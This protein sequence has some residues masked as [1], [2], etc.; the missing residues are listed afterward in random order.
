MAGD[1]VDTPVSKSSAAAIIE[2]AAPS[3]KRK[4]RLQNLLN[5]PILLVVLLLATVASCGKWYALEALSQA[6][7]LHNWNWLSHP[8]ALLIY[9]PDTD[10]GCGPGLGNVLNQGR[11]AHLDTVIVTDIQGK[12]LTQLNEMG[13]TLKIKVVNDSSKTVLTNWIG[14]NWSYKGNITVLRIQDGHVL[15]RTSGTNISDD[16]FK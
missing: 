12:R 8:N 4:R 9:Y 15:R 1:S 2:H 14:R 5:S 3:P 10:C 11:T 6:P 7:S 16:F 13:Q